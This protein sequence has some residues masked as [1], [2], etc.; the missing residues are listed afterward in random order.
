MRDTA[1]ELKNLQDSL[2][3]YTRTLTLINGVLSMLIL[4]GWALTVSTILW[5]WL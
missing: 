1:Q 2:K 5:Q 3:P 4:C